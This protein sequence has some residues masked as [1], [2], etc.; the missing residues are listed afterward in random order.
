[1]DEWQ[2]ILGLSS[3]AG[4]DEVRRAFK[5]Y[6]SKN[7]P[8]KNPD[9]DL[10]EVRTVIRG[11]RA[12]V[13]TEREPEPFTPEP[14]E[15]HGDVGED[16]RT[17]CVIDIFE[18]F[19]G[20]QKEV[21]VVTPKSNSACHEC[22][23]SGGHPETVYVDCPVCLG[24]GTVI[25]STGRS[26]FYK[27]TCGKCRGKGKLPCV[28]CDSCAG[29]GRARGDRLVNVWISP[30]TLPN[31]QLRV[32][33]HGGAGS[34][35]GDLIIL[36]RM[37]AHPRFKIVDG[38]IVQKVQLD[39]TEFLL[40]CEKP[41][42]FPDEIERP[43]QFQGAKSKQEF[44]LFGIPSQEGSQFVVESELRLPKKIPVELEEVLRKISWD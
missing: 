44:P 1:M 24:D 12:Y 30:G 42:L 29:S 16:V 3:K 17:E 26:T 31:S 13:P 33:G 23:G 10:D 18:F 38:N 11:Y 4:E 27:D 25:Q 15:F 20:A 6:I 21:R 36:V 22:R 43:V 19:R 39:L 41:V 7:H 40:G 32:R 9:A 34:P 35:P 28:P 2:Q 8:D 14:V 37:R 5:S